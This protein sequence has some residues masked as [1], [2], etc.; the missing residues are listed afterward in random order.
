M[1]NFDRIASGIEVKPLL[2]SLTRKPHLWN[3]NKFRTSFPN[4]PHVDVDDIL[5]RFSDTEKCDITT[6]VIGDD[7]P[8]FHPAWYELPEVR[9]IILDLMR[10]T[11]AYELG[12]V[13]ITRIP[14]GGQILPHADNDGSYV[15]TDDRARYHVVLQGLPGSLYTTGE[16]TVCM[17]S[18]EIWWFNA[19]E[20][21]HIENNSV[22]DRI[23]L[24]VDVRTM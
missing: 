16:E 1:R 7:Y 21:H 3:A 14:P 12:R 11:K 13:L 2:H 18:G 4:T 5:L 8:V 6:R 15:M 19:H 10:W 22:D 23:H 24:L 20:V 9:P 17:Q